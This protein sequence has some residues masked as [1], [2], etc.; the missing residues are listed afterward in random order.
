[1][2]VKR[3]LVL[4]AVL[5]AMGLA[6]TWWKTRTLALGYEAA[7]LEREIAR[8]LE[9][10]RLE[11]TRLARLTAPARVAAAVRELNLR[12][13]SRATKLVMAGERQAGTSAL[14]EAGRNRRRGT[15]H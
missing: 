13:E 2:R 1:V 15:G 5:V 8:G 6:T 11:E 14:A 12:L 9:E 4:V 7:R 10:E 3:Y